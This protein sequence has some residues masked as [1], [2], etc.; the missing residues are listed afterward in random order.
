MDL[1]IKLPAAQAWPLPSKL[2]KLV[3][4]FNLKVTKSRGGSVVILWVNLR[5]ALRRSEFRIQRSGGPRLESHTQNPTLRILFQEKKKGLKSQSFMLRPRT[6][7]RRKMATTSLDDWRGPRRSGKEV[8]KKWQPAVKALTKALVRN[9]KAL[10]KALVKALS[11]AVSKA[12]SLS[13]KE[14]RSHSKRGPQVGLILYEKHCIMYSL[15]LRKNWIREKSIPGGM[16]TL[17][18]GFIHS[19][20][21]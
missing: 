1:E 8:V 12:L 16:P 4:P 6:E 21:R 18:K 7:K 14:N 15:K 5:P 2:K 17:E 13:L 11:K 20:W 3:H 19:I 10:A 9:A